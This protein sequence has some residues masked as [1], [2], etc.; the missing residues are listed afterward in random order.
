M[1]IR[2]VTRTKTRIDQG[3]KGNQDK[4]GNADEDN[5]NNAKYGGGANSIGECLT[6]LTVTVSTLPHPPH[7]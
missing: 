5:A 1:K 3:N 7:L 6:N 2:K 4:E